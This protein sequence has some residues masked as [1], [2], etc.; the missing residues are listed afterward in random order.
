MNNFE[1]IFV[2]SLNHTPLSHSTISQLHFVYLP[3]VVISLCVKMR[4]TNK[5]EGLNIL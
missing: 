3:F 5:E 1:G 2:Q 4:D